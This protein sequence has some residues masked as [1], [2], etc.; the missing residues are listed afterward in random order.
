[1]GTEPCLCPLNDDHASTLNSSPSRF[2]VGLLRKI[3][4]ELEPA[5]ETGCERLTVQNHRSDECRRSVSLFPK[6]FR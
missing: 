6:Q 4:I 5:I 1:M 2:R 3:V